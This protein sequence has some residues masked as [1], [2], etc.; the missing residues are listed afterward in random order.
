M[1]TPFTKVYEAFFSKL[2]EDEWS[3]M[4]MDEI[5]YDLQ[6]ILD[7]AIVW[8]KFPRVSLEKNE[9]GFVS[10]LSNDEIQII[11]TYMKC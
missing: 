3:H 11:A 1:G 10:E 6:T 9:T 8:F 7:G 4:T 5:E 2:L